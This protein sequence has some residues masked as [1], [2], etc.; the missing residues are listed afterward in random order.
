MS[1]KHANINTIPNGQPNERDNPRKVYLATRAVG[2]ALGGWAFK[3]ISPFH[4]NVFPNPLHH[5]VVIV[6]DYFHQL[7]ATDMNG[8]DIYY[9]NDTWSFFGAWDR[10]HIGETTFN[11]VSIRQAG[12]TAIYSMPETYNIIHNNCQHFVAHLLDLV[13][14]GHKEFRKLDGTQAVEE[15]LSEDDKKAQREKDEMV[16]KAKAI[17]EEKTPTLTENEIDKTKEGGQ[18]LVMPRPDGP[19]EGGGE[20]IERETS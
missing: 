13:A 19:S 7:Q 12:E 15:E 18:P 20:I 16:R 3:F 5:W 6:G 2:G 9:T 14:P 10:Y 8:G 11:D 1:R 4:P 17:M